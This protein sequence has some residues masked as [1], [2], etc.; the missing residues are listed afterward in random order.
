MDIIGDAKR[1]HSVTLEFDGPAGGED[2][3]TFYN[4]RMDVTFTHAQT[5]ETLVIPGF[6]AADG[7]AAETGAT[8]GSKWHVNFT[9][10]LTGEWSYSVSFRSGTD[11]A[12][13][14]DVN[15]GVAY[16]GPGTID[17][18]AGTL[19][20]GETDKTGDDFRSKGMLDYV[21]EHY[22]VHAGT[23]EAFVK[24]GPG[25]PEN[26]LAYDGFDGTRPTHSF[27]PHLADWNQGDPTWAGGQGK[28]LIGAM[29]Y[30]ASEGVNS[31]YIITN[32][33]GGDG[34]DAW[35]WADENLNNIGRNQSGIDPGRVS[36]FDV[37]KLAQW[38][39]LFDHMDSLG[40]HR[41]LLLQETENDQLLNGGALGAERAVYY[42]E[43]IARFGGGLG[44]TWNLG[45][46]NTNTPAQLD[47]FGQFFDAVDPYSHLV[48]THTYP[49]QKSTV[50]NQ[51]IGDPWFDGASIQDSTPRN[52]VI[53]WREKSADAGR[54]WVVSWDETGPANRGLDPD[55]GASFSPNNQDGRRIEMWK[56]LMAGAAGVEWYFGYQNPHNDLNLED[57]RSRDAAWD[58]T[59]AASEFFETLPLT[60]MEVLDEL[61]SGSGNYVFA[62]EGEVY[63]VYLENGGQGNLDLSAYTGTFTVVWFDPR[64]GGSLQQSGVQTVE[65]GQVVNLG[66][67]PNQPAE[68]WAVLVTATG[69][70]QPN[71]DGGDPGGGDPGDGDPGDGGAVSAVFWLVDAQSNARVAQI[72]D[73]AM[74]DPDL[75]AS[76]QYS[77]EAE[78]VSGDV[79]SVRFS[80]PAVPTQT[81][82]V[83]PYALFGDA[84]GDFA[85]Q[86][87][88][89]GAL[90]LTV[91]FFSGPNGSGVL[92][93]SQS[94]SI[95]FAEA[96]DPNA[97][98]TAADDVAATDEDVAV[99][100]DVLANDGDPE[101]DAPLTI[102]IVSAPSSG[103]AQVVN[104]EIL[105][106]PDPNANGTDQL[107]Y[108]VRDPEGLASAPATVDIE[109]R[110]VNDAPVV[111]DLSRTIEE[112][113]PGFAL[114]LTGDDFGFDPDGDALYF[115]DVT[116]AANGD[117][118]LAGEASVLFYTP[119]PGFSGVE[120]LDVVVWDQ[121][122]PA[123]LSAATLTITVTAEPGPEPDAPLLLHA[124]NIGGGAYTAS[125]GISYAAD[126][127]SNAR[128]YAIGQAN[129]IAGTEDDTLYRSEAWTPGNLTYDFAVAE[130]RYRVDLLFAEIWSG[131]QKDNGRVFDIELEGAVVAQDVDLYEEVGFRTATT[132]SFEVEVSDGTLDIDL[133]KQIQNPKLSALRIYALD[134]EAEPAPEPPVVEDLARNVGEDTALSLDASDFGASP[135]LIVVA[136]A[137]AANG[138]VE[139]S[140]GGGGF[141]YTPDPDFD[142]EEDLIV[143]LADA[144]TPALTS[145]ARLDVDILPVNDA[146]VAADDV[147][148]VVAGETVLIDVLA[149]D[150]D[151]DGPALMLTVDSVSGPGTAVVEAGRIAYTAPADAADAAVIDY[152][153]SD[154]AGGTDTATVT[155]GIDP[156]RLPGSAYLDFFLAESA[157]DTTLLSLDVDGPV[158]VDPD[159]GNLLVYGVA[160]PDAE[161][162]GSVQ[163]RFDGSVQTENVT[164]Y[165]L[166]GDSG[167]DFKGSANFEAGINLVEITVFSGKRGTGEVLEEYDLLIEF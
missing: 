137:G 152:T 156:A 141:T 102:E 34:R 90:A 145:E 128:T 80:G 31:L 19:S 81:E 96:S 25:S 62:K 158:G 58:W 51:Q 14:A 142:G 114:T 104:G 49:N 98:P 94:L 112:N 39:I 146:P 38:G 89:D 129:D 75:V 66:A 164:P 64:N 157:T 5:G 103:D 67:G 110:P 10:P 12:A 124:I 120:T 151:I 48:V 154:G 69:N 54:K 16:A 76:G 153:V 131:A 70:V 55:T 121:Q 17:G 126:T 18:V 65:G 147:A 35:P 109:V 166:F 6:F 149:N 88:V 24:A 159:L 43:M 93:S 56:A 2:R 73:G 1:W 45:E 125:D 52:D 36:A 53:E 117:V 97:P 72:V 83:L 130:G 40:I 15:A 32:T 91:Q 42:R 61:T 132:K 8:S 20:I 148:T 21:G 71:P 118:V 87:V 155:V 50:Y 160:K 22:L 77:V 144:A 100:I 4:L 127:I 30:L 86:P 27:S 44:V 165:A 113:T 139:I 79:A 106:T 74:I 123:V 111:S 95:S 136:V 3:G 119:D 101:G 92:R 122:D 116:G 60:E 82:N 107:S 133:L 167:G 140:S 143:T 108:V 59:A 105:Y 29:N 99:S 37:S 63:L 23:G 134:E 46:E 163:L 11:V 84:G 47:A 150:S 135:D 26:I 78:V 33:A 9:P 7:N 68:D 115:F 85:G 13:S 161:A 57:F 162:F 138:E 28:E 41:H